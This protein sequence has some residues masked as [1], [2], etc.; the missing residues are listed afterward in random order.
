MKKTLLILLGIFITSCTTRDDDSYYQ[1][2]IQLNVNNYIKVYTQ[3]SYNVGD[4]LFIESRFNKLQDEPGYANKLDVFKTTNTR[5]YSFYIFLE[6]KVFNGNWTSVNLSNTDFEISGQGTYNFNNAI[7]ELNQ[8]NTFYEFY[9]GLIL[10]ESGQYRLSISSHINPFYG[11]NY[12]YGGNSILVNFYTTI[13]NVPGNSY[14]FT[15]N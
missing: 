5:Q 9:K 6:K 2:N 1:R 15:V 3:N 10:Q 14:E 11:N 12:F 8:S 13:E 7:C 4:K